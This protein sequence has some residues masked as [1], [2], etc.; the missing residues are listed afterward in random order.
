[1]SILERESTYFER[2]CARTFS[3]SNNLST[4]GPGKNNLSADK[5]F[6][7]NLYW[8]VIEW[9]KEIVNQC[10]QTEWRHGRE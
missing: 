2:T 3:P 10:N 1:M 8:L 7:L 4:Y 9:T 6:V 5:Y